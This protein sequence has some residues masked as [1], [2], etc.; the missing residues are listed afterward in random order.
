MADNAHPGIDN[1]CF[2]AS[3]AIGAFVM[4]LLISGVAVWFGI[5]GH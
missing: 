4:G 2:K 3:Y 1:V 5:W